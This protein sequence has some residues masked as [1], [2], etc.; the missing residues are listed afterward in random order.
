[1]SRW[2]S[3][4]YRDMIW[5]NYVATYFEFYRDIV[6]VLW[7]VEIISRHN[8]IRS[9]HIICAAI[10]W[11][12]IRN[13]WV[14]SRPMCRVLTQTVN[15]SHYHLHSRVSTVRRDKMKEAIRMIS[16]VC[17]HLSEKWSS[18]AWIYM[19]IT[20]IWLKNITLHGH[21]L[22]GMLLYIFR[23]K[24]GSWNNQHCLTKCHAYTAK[25]PGTP[26][27]L[28]IKSNPLRDKQLHLLQS[29]GWNCLSIPKLRQCSRWSLGMDKQSHPTLHWTWD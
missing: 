17:D 18:M 12:H 22:F 11:I 21:S 15:H 23:Q 7:L 24:G 13:N 4:V 16:V 3:K 28:W 25:I 27:L 1:M 29:V 5:K 14:I 9:R 20:H 19:S 26:L 8:S 2:N 10:G 6:F